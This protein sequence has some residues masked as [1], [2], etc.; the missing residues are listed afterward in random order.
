MIEIIIAA[1]IGLLLG[2]LVG[3]VKQTPFINKKES[4]VR[5]N[6]LLQ[7]LEYPASMP[8]DLSGSDKILWYVEYNKLTINERVLLE[9][10]QQSVSLKSIAKNIAFFA[11]I[12]II[13]IAIYF[14]L[15]YFYN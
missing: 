3:R 8:N 12:A 11:W 5:E 10:R 4:I 1:F 13:S 15:L 7:T 6:I 14:P 9:E 2:V